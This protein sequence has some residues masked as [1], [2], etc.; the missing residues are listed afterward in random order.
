M[1]SPDIE[2]GPKDVTPARGFALVARKIASD[3]DKTTTIYRRF[4]ELSARS[5]L[6]YQAEL[7]ELEDQLREYDEEDSLARDESSVECQRDWSE[8]ERRA[9]EGVAREKRRM[10]VVMKIREK[11]EKYRAN[12]NPRDVSYLPTILTEPRCRTSS[13]PLSPKRPSPVPKH[14]LRPPVLV[15]RQHIFLSKQPQHRHRHSPSLGRLRAYLRQHPRP[16]RLARPRR[17]RPPL[18]LHP[19]QLRAALPDAHS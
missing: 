13:P 10:D 7:A 6:F 9:S 4:D 17:P 2:L 12:P 15:L 11:L 18:N 3:I 16:R 8:F 1:P 5:L 14:S 19:K